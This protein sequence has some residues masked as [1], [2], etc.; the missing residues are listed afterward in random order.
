VTATLDGMVAGGFYDVVGGGFHRYSV[1][2]RWLVPHFEK[3]LYDNALLASTYLHAWVVTG[4]PRYREVVEETIGYVLREL[5]LPGGG[6]A[7]AH[8]ADTEGVEGL[9]YTWTR[10]EGDQVGLPPD[11][12]EP[13]EHGRLVVRGV[14]EP[15]LRARVLAERDRRPQ[16]FRD[17]KALASW[18]GL[19]LAALA[20]AGYRLE[21]ADWVDAARGLGEFLLGP[22]SAPDGR[23]LRSIRDGRTSGFGFLD[24]YANVAFGLMELHVATGAVRWLLEARR[25][26]LLAVELFADDEAG[27][28]FL[29]PADGD[30]RVPRT[31]DLQDTPI[32]SGN[33]MLASVLLRLSRL[34]ADEELERRAVSV[35]RLAEPSL[36][37]A[38]G[39]FAWMLCGIDLWLSAPRELAIV[40]DVEAAVARR[41]LEPFQP[42]TVVAIGP[43]EEVPLLAGK[44]L[45]DGRPAVYVCERFVC[46]APVTE[47]EEVAV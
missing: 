44:V 16:P 5:A 19:A 1:D 32:P 9:T 41:A 38:P 46:R 29:S 42:Q 6:I 43:S 47:P 20:E 3:M 36:R 27:G 17:D 39:Y 10:E 11:V 25:L 14:L 4:R 26:A 15:A 21:R 18:N 8:D 37:R 40:G 28:F 33:S 2:E 34:W 22:L 45:V 35:F 7:S 24:D 12:L 30:P 31:K 13:F 23:L